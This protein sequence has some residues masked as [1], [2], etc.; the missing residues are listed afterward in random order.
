MFQKPGNYFGAVGFSSVWQ[1]TWITLSV[2][3]SISLSLLKVFGFCCR[4][5]LELN[6]PFYQNK[7]TNFVF[8]R[9]ENLIPVSSR[10]KQGIAVLTTEIFLRGPEPT[11]FWLFR[12]QEDIFGA[13]N[14]CSFLQE[15]EI[16]FSIYKLK[17]IENIGILFMQRISE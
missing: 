3:K 2:C 8:T 4:I 7:E 5:K 9:I 16:T 15:T 10:I 11:Q 13:V 1:E 6:Y 14:F 17:K 12:E